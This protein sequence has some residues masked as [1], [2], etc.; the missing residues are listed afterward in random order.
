MLK[1]KG[2]PEAIDG[3]LLINEEAE[4]LGSDVEYMNCYAA[5]NWVKTSSYWVG[6]AS[7]YAM[8][9]FINA[10][11]VFDQVNFAHNYGLGVRPVIVVNTSDLIEEDEVTI[12]Y[13]ANEGTVTPNY[14]ILEK[15]T[16]ISTLPTPVRDNYVLDGWCTES[17]LDNKIDETYVVEENGTLYAKWLK[18]IKGSTVSPT[19]INIEVEGTETITVTNV[20][21]EYMCSSDDTNV[22][23]VNE[24]C[25]VTGTGAG[26]TTITIAGLSSTETKTVTVTVTAPVVNPISYVNRQNAGVISV[27]DEIAI[28]TEHF[29]VVST[30]STNTSLL[31]K[32]NLYVGDIMS[33]DFSSHTTIS[34]TDDG[35]GLQNPLALG[36]KQ[37][38]SQYVGTVAFS[39]SKYWSNSD[40]ANV[41]RSDLSTTAPEYT[42]EPTYGTYTGGNAQDNGY[43]IAYYV[44]EYVGRLKEI[45]AP[46]TITGRLLLDSEASSLGCYGEYMC[47]N[48]TYSWMYSTSYWVGSFS[49][50]VGSN[51]IGFISTNNV[52]DYNNYYKNNQFGV[53]PVIVINTTDLDV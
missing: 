16:A 4:D 46:D 38:L 40:Y 34:S 10:D 3:R 37:G 17:T 44:E 15:G 43:T 32:Y 35:Y 18:S 21:E 49:Q 50:D 1:E 41:Y 13:D 33:S 29:Y 30:K 36:Q 26:S 48:S 14:V 42:Y 52:Y 27:G 53:R 9:R 19:E 5:P 28:G 12:T 24:N 8:P 7:G 39:G 22:A 2:A 20:E 23:T 47:T 25:V 45:G 31:A 51:S 11:G 6:S